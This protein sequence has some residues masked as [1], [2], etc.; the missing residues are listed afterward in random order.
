MVHAA[1]GDQ[2]FQ[3]HEQARN[4][5]AGAWRASVGA[6][7]DQCAQSLQSVRLERGVHGGDSGLGGFDIRQGLLRHGVHDLRDA[8]DGRGGGRLSYRLILRHRSVNAAL[9]TQR[10][11]AITSVFRR[12]SRELKFG[13]HSIAHLDGGQRPAQVAG[14]RAAVKGCDHRSLDPVSLSGTTQ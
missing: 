11:V 6:A 8:P 14:A 3:Q 12:R 1:I 2:M 4:N 7:C 13:Q 5:F 9:T 10:G